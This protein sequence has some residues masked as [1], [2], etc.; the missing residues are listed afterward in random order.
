MVKK[1][2][3]H[4]F[5]R[6]PC[7]SED[8]RCLLSCGLEFFFCSS[9]SLEYSALRFGFISFKIFTHFF[10]FK[11]FVFKLETALVKSADYLFKLFVFF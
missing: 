11:S 8:S 9:F 4:E 1:L 2:F 7:A 10:S 6:L 3:K 5:A